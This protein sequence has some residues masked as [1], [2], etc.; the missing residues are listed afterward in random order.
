MK[1]GQLAQAGRDPALPLELEL[2]GGD[3]ATTLTLIAWLRVLPGQRYVALA[4]WQ[5]RRVLAKLLVGAR[6]AK[7]YRRELDGARLLAGQELT[8][9]H[10]LADGLDGQE[11]W[12]LF[13]F[14]EDA[15]SLAK[16]WQEVEAKVP[17]S[18][19]QAEVLGEALAAIARLHARGLWQDDLHLDNLLRHE[20]QLFLIDGGGV[21]AETPGEPLSRSRVLDNLGVFF[22][23]LPPQVLS[24]LEALLPAY[25]Q[26]N[27]IHELS[28]VAI[29]EAEA[30]VRRWRVRDYL[31]KAGR[32]CSLFS[33][34]RDAS[35]WR[36]V[37]RALEPALAPLLAQPD[38]FV[39]QGERFKGGGTATVARVELGGRSLVVKRYN[40]KHLRHHLSRCWR[41]SRAWHSWREAHRLT[42][43]GIATPAP[44]AVIEERWHGLRGRAF[45]V[46]DY[47]AGQDI[48]TCFRPYLDTPPPGPMLAAL[49]RL[50]AALIAARISHGDFKGTNLFWQGAEEGGRWVLIDLDSM[51]QH[52][53]PRGFERAYQR[54]RARF[55]RNWSADSPL[56]RL[57]D[58][59]IPKSSLK[60]EA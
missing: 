10:L 51:R 43:L 23:Q 60:P 55:M 40:I 3:E 18:K 48:I 4:D 26:V 19:G 22:A 14:L 13:E 16:A 35:S 36:A 44:L 12:L 11:G 7:Q 8:T 2:G 42:L 17:L 33:V 9:P 39:E 25:L 52:A 53:G 34:T 5:G 50:F 38:A 24:H 59:R 6:A 57:L 47:L 58:A 1:P 49:D 27:S 29:R 15:Q 21:R 32:D 37:V 20:G 28:S 41:P 45:L 54:D 30:R 46:T 56:H 31:D